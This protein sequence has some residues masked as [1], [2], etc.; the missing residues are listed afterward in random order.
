MNNREISDFNSDKII[1]Y[2]IITID[3]Y[4]TKAIIH[5]YNPVNQD[6]H[7]TRYF[8]DTC[9]EGRVWDTKKYA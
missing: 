7:W 2:Y 9:M 8:S 3:Q 6:F 4:L 1:T 5:I